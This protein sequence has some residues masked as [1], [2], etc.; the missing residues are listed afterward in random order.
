[1]KQI[2][3]V[4]PKLM[5]QE[6]QYALDEIGVK[7][8]MESAIMCHGQQKGQIMIYRGARFVANVVEKVKLE[9][10]AADDS[11]DK[12]TKVISSIV[13][14]GSNEDCRISLRPYLEAA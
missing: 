3:A 10:I 5:L 2:D 13:K 14:T 8:F 12:I 4:I 6:V 11:V 7:D 1:V 9:I